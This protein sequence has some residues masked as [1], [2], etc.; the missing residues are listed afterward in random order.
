[1]KEHFEC[2][3]LK[4]VTL[5]DQTKIKDRD[6]LTEI[7][8]NIPE[9]WEGLIV[10]KDAPSLFKRSNNLLKLKKF[11]EGEYKVSSVHNEYKLID[12]VQTFCC[13]SLSIHYKG[14]IVGVGSGI[15][16]MQRV[17]WYKDSKKIIGKLVTIKYFEETTDKNGK[18]SLRFPV[19]KAIHGERRDT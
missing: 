13:T 18:P 15:N 11:K 1:L 16:D 9:E 17:E 3:D 19:L 14:N 12:G 6:H 7:Y 10:R 8:K 2:T 4:N 5:L